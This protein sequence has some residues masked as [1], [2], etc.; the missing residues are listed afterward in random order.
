MYAALVILGR[1]GGYEHGLDARGVQQ[2]GGY[3]GVLGT[4]VRG[5][6][7]AD[8]V[9]LAHD[10]ADG[11]RALAN[12]VGGEEEGGP[13][14]VLHQRIEQRRRGQADEAEVDD[15]AGVGG[16]AA[17]APAAPVAA[18]VA[19]ICVVAADHEGLG[20]GE[21]LVVREEHGA[22]LDAAYVAVFAARRCRTR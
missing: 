1:G 21:E 16:R 17:A 2:E 11:V 18:A 13:D 20:G 9:A 6:E 5:A 19:D 15:A 7:R 22:V 14:A 12:L 3:L 10:A 4:R 8:A